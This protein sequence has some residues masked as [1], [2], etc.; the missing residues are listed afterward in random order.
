MNRALSPPTLP[1]DRPAETTGHGFQVAPAEDLLY[2]LSADG[3]RR[4]M[5]PV[6]RKG[7]FWRI[8]RDIAYALVVL[9]GALPFIS[10]GGYPAILFDLSARRFHVF[11]ATFHPTDNLLLAAFGFGVVVTV[12]FVGSTFG[13]MWCG[14]GCPQTVYLEFIFRPIERLVEGG[15]SAQRSLD[16]APWSRRK[17]TLKA[18]KWLLWTGVALAMS[19]TFVAYF[20]GWLPLARGVISDPVA[21]SGALATI[22]GMAGLIVFDF[23][24]FRD[25][26]CTIACPYGRL[27]NVMADQDTLV[28]AYDGARGEPRMAPKHVTAGV[29]A[30]DCIDCNACVAACPPA[31]TSGAVC[32]S[33]AS[34]PRSAW[35]R[36]TR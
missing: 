16:N 10:V 23:G 30:G 14:F 11:G 9:F 34:A 26:M 25:Q 32:R 12:F 31:P 6:V 7:R 8:R 28:V 36:A 5:H 17:L 27:Q 3:A 33:S 24:W 15:P 20:T 19:A 4:F 22:V 21:W 29:T 2:S 13:R 18:T 1:V 35:T